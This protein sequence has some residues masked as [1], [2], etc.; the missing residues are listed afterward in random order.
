VRVSTSKPAEAPDFD[1]ALEEIEAIIARIESG[2]IGLE[3]SI[4]EYE[5]GAALLRSCRERLTKAEQ[6]VRT[7]TAQLQADASRNAAGADDAPGRDRAGEGS[8]IAKYA[9][10]GPDKDAPF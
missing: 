3:Q 1:R 4:A 7:L 6:K 9:T 2:E 5:R 10:G 8:P